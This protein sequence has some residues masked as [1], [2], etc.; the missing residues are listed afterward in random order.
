MGPRPAR[1]PSSL[2]PPCCS[3]LFAWVEHRGQAPLLPL[4]TLRIKGLV[5]ANLTQLIA[6]AGMLAMFFFLTLYMQN[7]LGYSPIRTGAAYLPLCGVVGVAAGVASSLLTRVGT[8]PLIVAGS[9]I[10][11]GGVFLLSRIADARDVCIRSAARHVGHGGRPRARLRGGHHRCQRRRPGGPGRPRRRPDQRITASGWCARTG[12]ALGGR[13]VANQPSVG[14]RTF[15]TGCVDRRVRSR[16]AS[17]Q[18]LPARCR[19]DRPADAQRARGW[20]IDGGMAERLDRP[21][22]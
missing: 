4:P 1:S 13:D 12:R 7:V 15:G 17:R 18:H 9:L 14:S 2:A 22:P 19:S 10:A 5:A 16:P 3:L 21:S 6:I 20:S 11:S 8:R